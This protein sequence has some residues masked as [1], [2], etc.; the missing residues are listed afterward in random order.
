MCSGTSHRR[1]DGQS[2]DSWFTA[3]IR[4]LLSAPSTSSLNSAFG[5]ILESD[6]S[7][8]VNGKTVNKSGLQSAFGALKQK[9]DV[10]TGKIEKASRRKAHLEVQWETGVG[11]LQGMSRIR[12]NAQYFSCCEDTGG[13]KIDSFALDGDAS[14]FK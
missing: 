6:A 3:Q 14:L 5:L 11:V 12:L 4:G 10:S 13:I 9:W 1:R 8:T 7:G 2:F